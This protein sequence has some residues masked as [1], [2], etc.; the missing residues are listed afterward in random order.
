VRQ[1]Y[2]P[3]DTRVA[4]ELSELIASG[5]QLDVICLRDVGQPITQM[6]EGTRYWR[7]PLRH[8]QGGAAA[9]YIAE[10]A[11]FFLVT[12]PCCQYSNCC[13][14]IGLFR[15]TR[16]RRPGSGSGR[17]PRAG[18]AHPARPAR[19]HAVISCHKVRATISPPCGAGS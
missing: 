9:R 16:S 4:R 3:R 11:T 15:S 18:R 12:E 7:I 14:D 17:P 8:S 19:V 5:H 13:A 1:H 2:L 10:Y 6:R